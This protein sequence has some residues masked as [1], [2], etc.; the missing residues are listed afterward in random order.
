MIIM[1]YSLDATSENVVAGSNRPGI[2]NT[3]SSLFG[4]ALIKMKI[5]HF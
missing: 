2:N 4:M 1:S 5:V 3:Q